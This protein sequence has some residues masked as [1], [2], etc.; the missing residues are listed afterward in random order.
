MIPPR[1]C[2]A[3]FLYAPGRAHLLFVLG[4]FWVRFAFLKISAI[5]LLALM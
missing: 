3:G 2:E 4:L 1:I 5:G